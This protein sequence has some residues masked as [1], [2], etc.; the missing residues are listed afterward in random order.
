ME[1]VLKLENG[2]LF[3]KLNRNGGIRKVPY[4]KDATRFPTMG[5]AQECLDRAPT[6][7]ANYKCKSVAQAKLELSMNN[8]P[9]KAPDQSK[10]RKKLVN[11]EYD[12]LIKKQNI[13]YYKYE[14]QARQRWT[15][16]QR[17]KFYNNQDAKCA[18]CGE[19]LF[20]ADFTLDHIIPISMGGE[21]TEHNIQCTCWECNQ[22]KGSQSMER[23]LIKAKHIVTTQSSK[24]FP[25]WKLKLLEWILR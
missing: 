4:L 11:E 20:P 1:Y 10:N 15:T 7:L 18:I 21:D 19:T 5:V 9:I 23:T 16:D 25:K 12:N 8:Q 24:T 14:H 17:M 6:K 22:F 3:V 13:P 2:Q